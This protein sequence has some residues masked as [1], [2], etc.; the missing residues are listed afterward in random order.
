MTHLLSITSNQLKQAAVLK[1]RIEALQKE[2]SALL[3]SVP[4]PTAKKSTFGAAT[5]AKMVLAAKARWVKRKS[6]N[7][8]IKPAKKKSTMSA[9]G[10]ARI[11]AAA[12]ARW[13]KA[14]AAGKTSL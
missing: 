14:K 10:R 3:S 8:V 13:A 2:L 7:L 1:D 11:A 12:K 9:E 4:A 5:K 6:S